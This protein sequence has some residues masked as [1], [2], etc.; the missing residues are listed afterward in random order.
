MLIESSVVDPRYDPG[1][2]SR[3]Q[4]FY[5]SRIPNS[6]VQKAPD[7]ESGSV[8]LDEPSL[9]A[10]SDVSRQLAL[11]AVVPCGDMSLARVSL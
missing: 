4:I 5:P 8:T 6:G 1:Y 3:I 10:A 9:N 11:E 7:P 2:S